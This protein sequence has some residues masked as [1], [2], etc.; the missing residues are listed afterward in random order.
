MIQS[1]KLEQGALLLLSRLMD[2]LTVA[3]WVLT[4]RTA[5]LDTMGVGTYPKIVVGRMRHV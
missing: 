4:L 1:I 3:I 5:H 2:H